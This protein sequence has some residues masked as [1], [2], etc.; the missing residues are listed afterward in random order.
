[1]A[2]RSAAEC[3]P[4]GPHID[5]HTILRDG[6]AQIAI[7]QVAGLPWELEDSATLDG[8][9]GR[10]GAMH[11][12][13]SD[14]R[15]TL[16]VHLCKLPEGGVPPGVPMRSAYGAM[17][18]Q[19]YREKVLGAG[20]SRNVIYVSIAFEP[21]YP[22]GKW[23][24]RRTAKRT[25]GPRKEERQAFKECISSIMA[26]LAPYGAVLLG[27]RGEERDG[28]TVWYSQ[29][30]EALH[31]I[32]YGRWAKVP[33]TSGRM[34]NVI[35]RDRPVFGPRGTRV[36]EVRTP[37]AT[38]RARYFGSA[39]AW[40]DY[41]AETWPGMLNG[42]LSAPF[43]FVLTQ[44]FGYRTKAQS[45]GDMSLKKRQMDQMQDAAVD[46]AAALPHAKSMLMD[47]RWVMGTHHLSL[48]I[49]EATLPELDNSL[50]RARNLMLDAGGV[51][52]QEDW[53]LDAA[54]W[55]QIPGG[56]HKVH[57]KGK[58]NSANFAALAPLHNYPA[59]DGN[60]RWGGYVWEFRTSGGTLYPHNL[61]VGDV[62][63]T[64]VSGRTGK[65]KS[66]LL[67]TFMVGGVE[68]LGARCV[69]FDVGHGAE[70][71]IRALGGS[72]LALRHGEAS[73]IAPLAA[74]DDTTDDREHLYQ[75][76]LVCIIGQSEYELTQDEEDNLRR[77][78]AVQL[79]M[80]PDMR[81]WTG[82]RTPLGYGQDRSGAGARL[83]KWC[84]GG[85]LGWVF[86][87]P[88]D[89]ADFDAPAV[90]ID[91]T[92]IL[93]DPIVCGPMMAHLA[94]RTRKLADGHRL[95]LIWDEL[96]KPLA[97]PSAAKLID[98]ELRTIRKKEGVPILATQGP[99]E[100]MASIIGPSIREQTPT[101]IAF[102]SEGASWEEY[103]WLGF[104]GPEFRQVQQEMTVGTKRFL[105]HRAGASVVCEFDLSPI[106]DHLWVL[107]GRAATGK[108]L[109]RIRAEVGD[110]PA[111]WL[112]PFIER[113]PLVVAQEAKR[114]PKAAREME[115]AE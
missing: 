16:G 63:A 66:V 18:D 39:F 36:F 53:N 1:M 44:T 104:T 29:V 37:G 108:E 40:T 103:Q 107:S 52:A 35:L 81:S 14:P 27:L 89:L 25:R 26:N 86:A 93:D 105:I 72:Y 20:L 32:L 69:F 31:T 102:P 33:M 110:D 42:L 68:R 113:A 80:P 112:P 73:G 46:Q 57:R 8:L 64:F 109:A 4:L 83:E 59:G 90:G 5:A 111:D 62:G 85:A 71:C 55:A 58:I 12:N 2:E 30:G 67:N 21:D 28:H 100:V 95:M 82:L 43:G 17:L 78:V 41:P 97:I 87:N 75:L 9:Q 79:S 94:Y 51:V 98:E 77:A 3:I 34:G 92:M 19:D 15:L 96:H 13:Q 50:S 47:N 24:G 91:T 101:K 38:R 48:F 23:A 88:E 49:Y 6:G 61:H 56:W 70:P 22:M 7:A 76:A 10:M 54:F 115:P 11:R 99:A 60:P 74:L 45:L 84:E 106:A 65:G 114:K